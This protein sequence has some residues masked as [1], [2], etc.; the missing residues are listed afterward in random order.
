M[1]KGC[2]LRLGAGPAA[3]PASGLDTRGQGGGP[4]PPAGRWALYVAPGPAVG[5]ARGAGTSAG[6]ALSPAPAHILPSGSESSG[7]TPGGPGGGI[8]GRRPLGDWPCRV[9]RA[10]SPAGPEGRG[11]PAPPGSAGVTALLVGLERGLAGPRTLGAW[12]R[13]MPRLGA[14]QRP[15][16]GSQL[17]RTQLP[18][19]LSHSCCPPSPLRETDVGVATFRLSTA[20]SVRPG[21]RFLVCAHAPD[22]LSSCARRTPCCVPRGPSALHFHGFISG[23]CLPDLLSAARDSCS[24]LGM[25]FLS[26]SE[27]P[28]YL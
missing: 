20:C 7:C 4:R 6:S 18:S 16:R 5:R 23:W 15:A 17:E 11:P 26:C 13:L 22:A 24:S 25:P 14:P 10:G 2:H 1:A 9:P 8:T 19:C 12:G 3:C 28:K 21:R 27:D